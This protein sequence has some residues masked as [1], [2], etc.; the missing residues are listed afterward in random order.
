MINRTKKVACCTACDEEVF[1]ILARHSEGPRK[2]EARQVG[3]P[4]PGARR[5]SIVR[6][7]G[8]QSN[9]TM[10]GSCE[11]TSENIVE[12][13]RKELAAMVR[14]RSL[15]KDTMAQSE[16]REKMLKLF[17]WDIPVGVLGEIPWLEVR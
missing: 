6:I 7:S 9:W 12:L 16:M 2:G 17:E 5:L 1:E 13:N 3:A 4:L 10:C 8:R 11:V 15:A 14:E